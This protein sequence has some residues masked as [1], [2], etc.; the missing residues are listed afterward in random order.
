MTPDGE[1][2]AGAWLMEVESGIAA[3]FMHKDG[4]S[5]PGVMWAVKLRQENSGKVCTVMVK[6]LSAKGQALPANDYQAECA[7]EYVNT[8]LAQ[9]WDPD[10]RMMDHTIVLSGETQ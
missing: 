8:L 10:D 4:F 3:D 5:R 2:A 6:T 1:R 7:M 9:G